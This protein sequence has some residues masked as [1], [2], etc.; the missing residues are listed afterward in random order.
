VYAP[1]TVHPVTVNVD[2]GV[3]ANQMATMTKRFE[4][5]LEANDAVRQKTD[6]AEPASKSRKVP[7]SERR[8]VR[9]AVSRAHTEQLDQLNR[10][11]RDIAESFERF[12]DQTQRTVN[13][14]SNEGRRTEIAFEEIR[15]VQRQLES[16]IER[17]RL[18]GASPPGVV[19]MPTTN[20][21]AP[22]A[23]PPAEFPTFESPATPVVNETAAAPAAAPQQ[24]SPP[25]IAAFSHFEIP[26]AEV[27]GDPFSVSEAESGQSGHQ[28][29]GTVSGKV[30]PAAESLLKVSETSATN[31]DSEPFAPEQQ[32]ANSVEAV[33]VSAAEPVIPQRKEA[34]DVS[35]EEQIP[36]QTNTLPMPSVRDVDQSDLLLAYKA[37]RLMQEAEKALEAGDT[38]IACTRAM[39]ARSLAM[40]G[41]LTASRWDQLAAENQPVDGLM[42]LPPIDAVSVVDFVSEKF[43]DI[44][45]DHQPTPQLVVQA[46][47]AIAA[48]DFRLAMDLANQAEALGAKYELHADS[49]TRLREDIEW[50]T[51]VRV[52]ASVVVQETRH[53]KS[54]QHAEKPNHPA[55]KSVI[56]PLVEQS[57]S[58]ARDLV[59][60]VVFEHAYRF[61]LTDVQPASGTSGVPTL[62]GT[63][64]KQCGKVHGPAPD[65]QTHAPSKSRSVELTAYEKRSGRNAARRSNSPQSDDRS[66]ADAVW[67]SLAFPWLGNAESSSESSARPEP[68]QQTEKKKLFAPHGARRSNR[69]IQ[70]ASNGTTESH[71]I[72]DTPVLQPA[73]GANLQDEPSQLHRLTSAI[74]RIGKSATE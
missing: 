60:P 63:P 26:A 32:L 16:Q 53:G 46:R 24:V 29:P 71:T 28:L 73:S 59:K 41:G 23:S 67:D 50:L 35:Q 47:A 68:V 12:Q 8:T 65:D 30:L 11:L 27:Q 45:S 5:L 31:V 10:R 39:Q 14:I 36:P 70:E 61:E 19:H 6:V 74:R 62:T 1:I 2:G 17:A 56:T 34:S 44:D 48:R 72:W 18:A 37:R 9:P 55:Q 3:F 21:P 38:V 43:Q 15:S 54:S 51:G 4:E 57:D 49:P 13:E 42:P 69:R 7:A 20:V 64:C 33:G 66:S 25:S 52:P 22:P 40:S 58:D